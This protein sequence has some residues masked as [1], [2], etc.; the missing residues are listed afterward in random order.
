MVEKRNRPTLLLTI[1]RVNTDFHSIYFLYININNLRNE[2]FLYPFI[3]Y[4]KK[5]DRHGKFIFSLVHRRKHIW[6]EMF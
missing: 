1:N 4:C 6:T 5:I 2:G 3:Y